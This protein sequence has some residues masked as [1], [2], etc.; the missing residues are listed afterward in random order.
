[1]TVQILQ[2]ASQDLLD[3]FRFYEGQEEGLGEYFI[4]G[5]S[6]DID[7]L[8][9]YAAMHP[10]QMGYHKLLSKRF[11]YAIYYR[12]EGDVAF[13]HAILDCRQDPS[14]IRKRLRP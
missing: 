13:V 6:S 11:P 10:R 5:L 14:R 7:S 8:E 3:G 2:G 12:V 1:M 9:L 4:D